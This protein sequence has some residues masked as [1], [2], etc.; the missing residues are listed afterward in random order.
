MSILDEAIAAAGVDPRELHAR[1]MAGQQDRTIAL[2]RA[3]EEAGNAAGDVFQ[4]ARRAHGEVAGGLAATAHPVVDTGAQDGQAWRLLGQGGQDMYIV[5]GLLRR[6]V[7]ALDDAQRDSTG[8]TNQMIIDLNSTAA[9][10]T[11]FARTSPVVVPA[12]RQAYLDRAVQIVNTAAGAIQ[13]IIDTYDRMLSAGTAELAGRGFVEAPAGTGPLGVDA[14]RR[15]ADLLRSALADPDASDVLLDEAT[16]TAQGIDAQLRAGQPLTA[17][18]QRY[19]TEFA[20]AAGVDALAAIPGF[21]DREV[22]QGA[23]R[24]EAALAGTLS[25]LTNPALGGTADPAALPAVLRTLTDDPL[26]AADDPARR[27]ELIPALDALPRYEGVNQLLS[28]TTV[29]LGEQFGVTAGQQALRTSQL[30]AQLLDPQHYPVPYG[31]NTDAY[32]AELQAAARGASLQLGAVARNLDSAQ[33]LLLIPTP[34]DR[35]WSPRTWTRPVRWR[36]LDRATARVVPVEDIGTDP[37]ASQQAEASARQNAEQNAQVAAAVL[38]DLAGDPQGWREAIGKDTPISAEITQI[39]ADNINAFGSNSDA[40]VDVFAAARIPE[41]YYGGFGLGKQDAQD[42]LTFIGAGRGRTAPT[43]TWSGCTRPRRTSPHCRCSGRRRARLTADPGRHGRQRGRSGQHGGLPHGDAGVRRRRR[44]PDAGVREQLARRGRAGREGGRCGDLAA[45]RHRRGRGLRAGGPGHRRLQAGGHRGPAGCRAGRADG[46]STERG[47]G[48][49]G[50]QRPG[51]GRWPTERRAGPRRRSRRVR[52]GVAA[53]VLPGRKPRHRRHRGGHHTARCVGRGGPA[54]AERRPGVAQ[55]RR[56]VPVRGGD[57]AVRAR[58]RPSCSGATPPAGVRRPGATARG[59]SGAVEPAMSTVRRVSAGIVA[60]VLA[61]L[62]A[63]CGS[64]PPPVS[65]Y[66]DEPPIPL[67]APVGGSRLDFDVSRFDT[68]APFSSS[69]W[70]T[71]AILARDLEPQAVPE[72]GGGC[73]WRGPGMTATVTVDAGRSLAEYSNDP[74]FRP[75]GTGMVGN[76]FW[77]TAA[78]DGTRM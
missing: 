3:F 30:T 77:R 42:V 45:A 11:D 32:R 37:L 53:G 23:D 48:P 72:P 5:A 56:P 75:G 51:A 35:C 1:L 19:L 71:T 6:A 20:N 2:S 40:A 76:R 69:Y 63:A 13:R 50:G 60:L 10:Y 8:V 52:S 27:A 58:S 18:Q 74:Q 68:C 15:D 14:A 67:S 57:G 36:L 46:R 62:A 34:A 61:G 31:F 78:S 4:R 66:P 38:T 47:A 64:D 39:V 9:A 29:P 49:S 28:A 7:V 24:A 73:R 33:Q 17:E 16:R 21:A 25:A 65:A 55:R 26:A 54:R 44:R 59:G 41:G 70:V 22:Q 43:P 12:D